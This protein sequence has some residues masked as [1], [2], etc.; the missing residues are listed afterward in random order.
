[1]FNPSGV[2]ESTIYAPVAATA[3]VVDASLCAR[4]VVTGIRTGVATTQVII[5][6][7]AASAVEMAT[8]V[9]DSK[10]SVCLLGRQGR[11]VQLQLQH[12]VPITPFCTL[13]WVAGKACPVMI[14]DLSVSGHRGVGVLALNERNG[15]SPSFRATPSPSRRSTIR[16]L[17]RRG[18]GRAVVPR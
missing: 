15:R 2:I 13:L 10:L 17:G 8:M 4:T 16:P 12:T 1:M 6:K 7:R 18:K 5:T 9:A 3:G 14:V 11:G